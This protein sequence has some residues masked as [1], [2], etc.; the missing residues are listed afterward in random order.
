MGILGEFHLHLMRRVDR[1]LL[2]E[3]LTPALV[4]V[5]MMLMLL[6]G[7]VLYG[8]LLRLYEA[9]AH[10]TDILAVLFY[11]L[12]AVLMQAVPGSLLLGTALGITRLERDRELLALRMAGARL[13]RLVLPYLVVGLLASA[14]LF[15]L[16]ETV[17]PGAVHTAN[18]IMYNLMYNSP[19]AFIPPDVVF[20][21][22]DKF[23]YVREVN[24]TLKTLRTVVILKVDRD[25]LTLFTIPKA[26]NRNGHWFFAP[27]PV[28]KV[29]PQLFVF[30][31]NG[32]LKESYV[33]T[34]QD[35]WLNLKE[36]VW[37][38]MADPPK[39]PEELTIGE[40]RSLQT[41]LRGAG[42]GYM[43]G[44]FLT[45]PQLSF[46]FHRKM[47]MPLAALVAVLIAVPLAVRFGRTGGYVGLLLSMLVAFFFV[48]SQQWAA[49]LA[50]KSAPLLDPVIAAWAPDVVFGLLGLVL[51]WYAE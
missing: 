51:L 30:S 15:V 16:Q 22:Q 2:S 27:D 31:A 34:G 43:P 46:Y 19:S 41:G 45:P 4:G 44:L 36:D 33:I 5:V 40:L 6:I 26:T 7:N 9:R 18:R 8:V 38:Y 48:I 37:N 50:V 29:P 3:M 32:D 24:P 10:T 47:A 13:K 28:T 21:V 12:P 39:Q 25:S 14:L 1:Y 42:I 49:V 35:N 17:I 20:K 23:L 11:N